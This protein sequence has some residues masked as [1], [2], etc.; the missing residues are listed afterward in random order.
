MNKIPFDISFK[1]RIERGEVKVVTRD[2]REVTIIKWDLKG[3]YPIAACVKVE[4]CNYEGDESWFEERP[5]VFSKEGKLYKGFPEDKSDIFILVEE[6]VNGDL[7]KAS[8]EWLKPQLDKSYAKYGETKMME[9]THFDGYAMLD[10]I[11]FGAKW[12]EEH[13]QE[14][15]ASED[16]EEATNNYC[17]N[18]RKG[19]PRVKDETDRYICS[20]FKAGAQ[21]QKEQFEK[22]YANLCKGIA[23]AKGLA[24]TMAYDKGMADAREQMMKD[25]YDAYVSYIRDNSEAVVYLKNTSITMPS[26]FPKKDLEEGDK[27]KIVIIKED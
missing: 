18:A 12:R 13:P 19:Y 7:E 25:A 14:K 5:Y 20:A 26:H 24:V 21:W 22:D 4:V 10:A 23:T 17:L 3:N 2:N 1:E 6:P 15:P 8:K 16:L 9:L 11:E 27:L